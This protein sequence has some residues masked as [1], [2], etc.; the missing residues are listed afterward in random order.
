M[1]GDV[2]R[3]QPVDYEPPDPIDLIQAGHDPQKVAPIQIIGVSPTPWTFIAFVLVLILVAM[4]P[5]YVAMERHDK[6]VG[7]PVRT[8]VVEFDGA[9]VHRS[10]SKWAPH[11]RHTGWGGPLVV[12]QKGR[13]IICNVPTDKVCRIYWVED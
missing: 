3:M 8:W 7:V 9:E 4:I 13:G 1:L 5:L 2:P 10:T 12:S 11:V 6:G